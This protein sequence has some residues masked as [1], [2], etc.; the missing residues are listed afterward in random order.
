M[1]LAPDDER[2]RAV[3]STW[4]SSSGQRLASADR[5]RTRAARSSARRIVRIDALAV[6][7][8]PA[9][10]RR[11]VT[12]GRSIG[13]PA[14]ELLKARRRAWRG[15]V[16][17]DGRRAPPASRSVTLDEDRA[18]EAA[19]ERRV[20]DPRVG[21]QAAP[22]R[23]RGRATK[24]FAPDRE[25]ALGRRSRR[26]VRC[27]LP[28]DLDVGDREAR[29]RHDVPPRAPR[30]RRPTRPT[31]RTT[32]ATVRIAASDAA[33][34]RRRAAGGRGRRRRGATRVPS[35]AGRRRALERRGTRRLPGRHRAPP[36]R[37]CASSSRALALMSPAPSAM[38]RSPGSTTSSERARRPA[39]CRAR[40]ARRG[41]RARG[42]P[43]RAP[44]PSRPRWASRPPA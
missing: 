12:S 36:R 34:R 20:G 15:S 13:S 4:T 26:R 9:S 33:Q 37:A 23:R 16:V 30:D 14:L 28:D 35:T 27:S 25:A 2:E 1:A 44:R 19:R 40:S 17:A 32:P 43:R 38:T 24:T 8:R 31:T 42:S 18:G 10:G 39:S 11:P 22:A 5:A 41:G 7:R 6:A 21:E 3:R 29:A